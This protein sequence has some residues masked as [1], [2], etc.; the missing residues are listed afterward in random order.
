MSWKRDRLLNEDEQR[1]VLS[2]WDK[3][4]NYRAEPTLAAFHRAGDNIQAGVIDPKTGKYLVASKNYVRCVMGPIGSGKSVACCIEIMRRAIR[5]PASPDGVRRS[6]IAVVRDTFMNLKDSTL[7]TWL[8]WF[9]EGLISKV[10]WSPPISIRVNFAVGDGTQVDLELFTLGLENENAMEALKSREYTGAWINECQAIR[11]SVVNHLVNRVGRYPSGKDDPEK[12]SVPYIIMDTN[13]P[14]VGNWYHEF[15]EKVRPA[16]WTF[17]RQP[18]ALLYEEH[19]DKTVFFPNVGQRKGVLPAENIGNLREGF[20]YYMKNVEAQSTEYTKVYMCCEYGDS[21]GGKPVYGAYKD[22]VHYQE[23]AFPFN[24]ALP[25]ILGFD[26][27]LTPA[28]VICQI[29]PRGQVHVLEEVVGDDIGMRQFFEQQLRPRLLNTYFWGRGVSL[30]AV[31][32][33]AGD[34]RKDT[35]ESTAAGVLRNYGVPVVACLTNAN[36]A[37]IDS[38]RVL[39]SRFSDGKHPDLMIC[40]KCPVLRDGFLGNYRYAQMKGLN[41]ARLREVP[42][43]NEY[44][45]IHDALQYACHMILNP[46][47]YDVSFAGGG[48]RRDDEVDGGLGAPARIGMGGFF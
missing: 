36:S 17:F 20:Q 19:G 48:I 31:G 39:L 14:N 43:K 42:E 33:P 27:G 3:M 21:S 13:P 12:R 34:F 24:P 47:L 6:R 45:H 46:E 4:N 22:S 15:A 26:Y 11:I 40:G 7:Q 1:A 28:C 32:D 29:T 37:R 9:P 18:P 2:A 5:Q 23:E 35:D 8:S 30:Y 16:G 41:K 38:V 10:T 44:S 25:L